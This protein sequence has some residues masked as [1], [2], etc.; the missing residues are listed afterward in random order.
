[1]LNE[2]AVAWVAHQLP[3]APLEL[4]DANIFYPER[5]TLAFSEH[6]FVQGVMGAPFLWAG[7]STLF[8]HNLL[9]LAGFALSG[10]TTAL[11]L[12][13][14]TG[15]WACGVLAGMLLAFNSHTLARIAHLQA[16]HL[17]FIP[18]TMFALDRLLTRPRIGNALR[19]SA[20]YTLQ[21][22]TSNYL[23]VFM[24]FGLAGAGLVR[25]QDWVGRGRLRV[26]ALVCLSAVVAVLLLAPFL[27]HYLQAQRDQGLTRT[28][29]E[30]G[31]YAASWRDYLAATGNVH[32]KTWSAVF[33]RGEGA[34]LFPGVTATVLT[35]VALLSGIAWRHPAA[36]M[37]LALA[38]VGLLLSFGAALP[39]YAYLYHAVPL[40]QGI[41]ASVRFGFL[42]LVGMAC[43]SAFGLAVLR[44][45][46]ES[47]PRMRRAVTV[48]ALT[49][50]TIEAL[51]IPVPY[52][53]PV[54]IPAAYAMLKEEPGAVL[55]ELPLYEPS[56]FQLNGRYMLFSTRHWR[57]IVN[58]YSGFLPRS[59]HEH[60]AGLRSFPDDAALAYLR[61]IGVTH[62]A[63]H[64]GGFRHP[65][66]QEQLKAMASTPGLRAAINSPG[67]IIYKV[68]PAVTP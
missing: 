37:W 18:L 39:G 44:T 50:V 24:T 16:V 53:P 56:A 19:L 28:L 35:L 2:W 6:M 51:R 58:G 8:V 62:V 9:I 36:R 49:L 5:N 65:A 59:Y 38:L 46:F 47:R 21:G 67:L 61:R 25:V 29:E 22:L 10:W 15:S 12:R 3:R 17:Q 33:W 64:P 57:P 42:V 4:F 27:V 63:V 54:E 14:R 52:S 55:L 23:L 60:L 43:L 45:R 31:R 13:R 68:R 30:V 66:G 40:L 48:A 34:P 26:F 1:M 7:A 11:V 41:R 32:F 20:V